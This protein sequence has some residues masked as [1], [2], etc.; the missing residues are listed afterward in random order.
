MHIKGISYLELLQPFVQR[1]IT[2][3]AIVVE[4]IIRNNSVK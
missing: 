2:I 1:S 4:G 3:F